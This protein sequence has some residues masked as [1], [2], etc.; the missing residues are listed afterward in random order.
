LIDETKRSRNYSLGVQK[1]ERW[2]TQTRFVLIENISEV[3]GYKFYTGYGYWRE[4]FYQDDF[5]SRTKEKSEALAALRQSLQENGLASFRSLPTI[6]SNDAYDNEKLHAAHTAIRQ[7]I[8]ELIRYEI[9]YYADENEY[10]RA[11]QR[12]ARWKQRTQAMLVIT[13]SQQEAEQ[14]AEAVK[15]ISSI[16]NAFETGKAFLNAL[17]ES[18]HSHPGHVFGTLHEVVETGQ[19]ARGAMVKPRM[20]I[21]SSVEGLAVAESI[22]L[23]LRH[24][25]EVVIWTQGPFGLSEGSLESLVK[26][27]DDFH[28][29]VFVLTPDDLLTKRNKTSN[30][31]R[32]NVLFELGLFMGALGR[33]RTFMV[34]CKDDVLDLPTDLAGVTIASYS[35]HSDNNLDAALGPVCTLIKRA[36]QRNNTN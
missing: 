23:G 17:L 26:A 34:Q 32:D 16:S 33:E 1:F 35:K 10:Q 14:F 27:K 36:I 6:N 20:F 28:Y 29:A 18:I 22:Q 25:I 3:E 31:P 13:V 21:G 2:L 24:D 19:S 7:H 12:I 5:M 8:H 11:Y 4:S 15:D 30:S 9:E